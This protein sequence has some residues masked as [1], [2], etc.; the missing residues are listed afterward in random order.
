VSYRERPKVS[1][2]RR[3]LDVETG[4]IGLVPLRMAKNR[5]WKECQEA[6]LMTL[7]VPFPRSY[8]VVPARLLAGYYPGDLNPAEARRKLQGLVDSGVRHIIN[9]MQEDESNWDGSPFVPY[10][11]VLSDITSQSGVQVAVARIPIPDLDVPSRGTM[12]RILDEIDQ[13]VAQETPVYVH[14]RG[15]LGRTGTVVGCYLAR[16]HIAG[17]TAALA[18]LQELRKHTPDAHTPSPETLEQRDMVSSWR[19]G[20]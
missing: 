19:P 11:N 6:S 8:W 7:A 18:M 20:E 4:Q 5:S 9:L 13:A 10:G 12:R 2:S 3:A 14:C 16:H 1:N 15:G 17:G